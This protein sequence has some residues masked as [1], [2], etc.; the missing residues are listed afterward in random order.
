MQIQMTGPYDWYSGA[1]S[2]DMSLSGHLLVQ[3]L[4]L[5]KASQLKPEVLEGCKQ[6]K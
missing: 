4:V 1:A 5:E 3:L 2:V 6:A